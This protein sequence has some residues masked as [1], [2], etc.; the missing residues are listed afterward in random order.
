[1]ESTA[2]AAV[3]AHRA[4]RLDAVL[5][6]RRDDHALVLERVAERDLP[7]K[8][9]LV[10]GLIDLGRFRQVVEMDEVL[11]QPLAIRLCGR[12]RPLDFLVLDNPALI[13]IDE[14]HTA[15]LQ[16]ALLHDLVGR[17]V[18][19]AGLRGHDDEPVFRDVET[20]RAQAV[21]VED[22]ADLLAVGE[23]DR[24]RAVPRLHQAGVILVKRAAIVVHRLMVGPRLG[25]HHH[26][27]VR[28]RTA[29]E[30]EQL[31]RVVEHRGV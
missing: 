27:R 23:C 24:G 8:Q 12:D 5:G 20:R 25:D 4:D 28:Q 29:G 22:R 13:R 31:E 26:H 21:A 16:A 7:L 10:V 1:L 11:V 19:H 14:E 18:E 15:G 2:S 17:D 3:V 6:H 9:R 30:H